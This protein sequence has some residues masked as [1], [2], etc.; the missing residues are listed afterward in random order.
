M[1]HFTLKAGLCSLAAAL[2]LL[3]TA[4][5]PMS[6]GPASADTLSLE[7]Q[8]VKID[9]L[10]RLNDSDLKGTFLRTTF[11][12]KDIKETARDQ[13]LNLARG[14]ST[15]LNVKIDIR[16]EWIQDDNLEFKVELVKPGL[17]ENVLVRCA[18]VSREVTQFNRAMNCTLPG[19]TTPFL[20]FRLSKPDTGLPE[21]ASV[22]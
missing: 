12:Q 5:Q 18:H 10:S 2:L 20:T 6:R 4:Q 13:G 14:Q 17:V 11:K 15:D 9:Q 16:P 22:R 19:E 8:S 3:G 7:L 1:K 21:V